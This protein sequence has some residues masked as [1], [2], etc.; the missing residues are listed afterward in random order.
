MIAIESVAYSEGELTGDVDIHLTSVK[1]KERKS[2]GSSTTY[3][4]QDRCR[5]CKVRSISMCSEC[6]KNASLGDKVPFICH[7]TTGRNGNCSP[8]IISSNWLG[9]V[10]VSS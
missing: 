6:A 5:V 10:K 9:V 8:F 3:R 7:T 1:R 2:D 4:D